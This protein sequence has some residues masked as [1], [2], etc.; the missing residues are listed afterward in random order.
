ML[1]RTQSSCYPYDVV[2]PFK[3]Y[4]FKTTVGLPKVLEPIEDWIAQTGLDLLGNDRVLFNIIGIAKKEAEHHPVIT[5]VVSEPDNLAMED[6][7]FLGFR[8]HERD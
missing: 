8:I 5:A 1:A 3:G 2:V 7:V 4:L 6:L